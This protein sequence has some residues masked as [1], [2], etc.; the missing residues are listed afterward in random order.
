MDVSSRFIQFLIGKQLSAVEFVR[1][2]VQLRFDGPALTAFDW[3][4][5]NFTAEL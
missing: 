2:H 4:I 1:D 3:L 5:V